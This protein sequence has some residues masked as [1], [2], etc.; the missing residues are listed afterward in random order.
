MKKDPPD[1]M[2]IALLKWILLSSFAVPKPGS[3]PP[4]T[5]GAWS[6]STTDSI[7]VSE[8]FDSSSILDGTTKVNTG[9]GFQ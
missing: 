6:C 5:V 7:R 2:K 8:A 3:Q 4:A 9:A 1:S